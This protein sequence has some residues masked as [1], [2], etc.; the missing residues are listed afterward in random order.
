MRHP[1]LWYFPQFCFN[2][3]KIS[4]KRYRRAKLQTVFRRMSSC[5]FPFAL[6]HFNFRYVY[7]YKVA[8]AKMARGRRVLFQDKRPRKGRIVRNGS[9]GVRRSVKSIRQL[10]DHAENYIGVRFSNEL[11]RGEISAG[12]RV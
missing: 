11:G 9:R 12:I 2:M 4:A 1:Q 3:R 5:D 6:A 8:R 7:K 10:F